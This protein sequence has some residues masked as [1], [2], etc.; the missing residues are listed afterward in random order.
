MHILT[1]YNED[2]WM[3]TGVYYW[4]AE[5][6]E[7]LFHIYTVTGTTKNHDILKVRC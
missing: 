7:H 6:N 2:K 1:I 4:A 3:A 5:R